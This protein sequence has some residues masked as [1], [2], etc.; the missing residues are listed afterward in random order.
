VTEVC[1]ERNERNRW[2]ISFPS[3]VNTYMTCPAKW[4]FR[5]LIGLSEPATG[6]LASVCR[7]YG[8]QLS[9]ILTDVAYGELRETPS[10][11]ATV[12][13]EWVNITDVRGATRPALPKTRGR[14]T[15]HLPASVGSPRYER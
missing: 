12:E 13:R 15:R 5:Y 10:E 11:L 7:L 14:D 6:A 1:D 8:R 4:Y 9:L 2:G 3:Q